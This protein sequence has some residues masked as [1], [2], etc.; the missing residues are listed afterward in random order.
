VTSAPIIHWF[1]LD[2]RLA[3]N[4]AFHH[5]AFLS[6]KEKRPL[7]PLFIWAPESE[8]LWQPGGASKW[9]L[10][11]ALNDLAK[12][13]DDLGTPLIIQRATSKKNLSQ[14]LHQLVND[15]GADTLTWNRH[16]EP[17]LIKRDSD[18]KSS[19]KDEG[20][21]VESFNGTL[22]FE[23]DEIKNKSGK[24]FQVFT[25]FWKHLR[26]FDIPTALPSPP[27]PQRYSQKIDRL[28]T[29]D[30]Q[31]LPSHPHHPEPNWHQP[32]EEFWKKTPPS[33]KGA[34]DLLKRLTPI[35]HEYSDKRDL[36][37]ED[38]TSRLAAAL[39]FG[40]ISP[41]EF[42]HHLD[43]KTGSD[44]RVHSGVLRQLFWREFSAH[45]LY[46][47]PHSQESSLRPEYASFPTQFNEGYLTAW[48]E[49]KTGY[50]IVDAGMRQL[51]QTGWMHNRVRMITASLL[52]KHMLQPWQEGAR[53]FWDTLCDADLANNTMGWQWV[54]GCGA[55]AAPYFR[56][57]NPIPQGQKFDAK[58]DYIRRWVPELAALPDKY[59]NCPWEMPALE[60]AALGVTLGKDYPFPVIEHKEG[61]ERALVAFAKHKEA[62]SK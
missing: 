35:A 46:H 20:L 44:L 11:H 9:W 8:G 25:P 40:Q 12:Q 48:Q 34:L 2:L 13:L 18:L 49:G 14:S 60:L 21:Q 51:W 36:P 16:Y 39:H 32:L 17:D 57:F 23:P 24:P 45:L 55:D 30:L 1:R 29:E 28:E 10:H 41:R 58:G 50:P 19:L 59:L 5:A 53:W 27:K 3:D 54:A 7:I 26:E 42:F 61:R 38:A 56:I 37:A 52:V 47:F 33:R 4:P 43:Q 15:T 31:L 22:L 6:A 62:N